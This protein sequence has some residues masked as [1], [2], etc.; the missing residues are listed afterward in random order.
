[1]VE[2]NEGYYVFQTPY[3]FYVEI[4]EGAEWEFLYSVPALP[5]NEDEDGASGF[6]K[7][8]FTGLSG[9]TR[10]LRATF[11]QDLNDDE[12]HQN[13]EPTK[14]IDVNVSVCGLQFW[15]MDIPAAIP[16]N[17]AALIRAHTSPQNPGPVMPGLRAWFDNAPPNLTVYWWLEVVYTRPWVPSQTQDRVFVPYSGSHQR[18]S[19]ESFKIF[20]HPDWLAH[21]KAG[22][23]GG[24]KCKL[25]YVVYGPNNNKLTPK[26]VHPFKIGGE[27]PH[28]K[29]CKDYIISQS[30]T[31]M[32]WFTYAIA[33]HESRDLNGEG[34]R[35]NQFWNVK[36][37]G[38]VPV[39][40]KMPINRKKEG[41]K[42]YG[43]FGVIQV[44]GD[45]N[46]QWTIIPRD[47]IWNWQSNVRAGLVI[48]KY[49]RNESLYRTQNAFKWMN[50]TKIITEGEG[51][52]L[53][54]GQRPQMEKHRGD[55]GLPLLPVPDHLEYGTTFGDTK[56][57]TRELIEDAVNIRLYNG[58][59]YCVYKHK[60]NNKTGGWRFKPGPNN[61][62]YNVCLQLE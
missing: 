12:I 18:R 37:Y 35:Y 45:I 41:E 10:I 24:D 62:V 16:T 42:S 4:E 59:L 54:G 51:K 7:P 56:T 21:V 38:G 22:F 13:Y 47:Q 61:Y 44:T 30:P 58:G 43:G 5:L 34:T 33:K 2:Y 32:K 3:R 9:S 23:F 39:N 52:G 31:D 1:M 8:N 14:N 15:Q 25:V 57:D 40:K 28:P 46:S 60:D 20:D 48:I 50:S 49:K 6:I 29:A 26:I 19:D 53:P 55:L 17:G 11:Y 27:N 36:R